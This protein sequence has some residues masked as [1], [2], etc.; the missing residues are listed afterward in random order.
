[1]KEN[2]ET[3]KVRKS[4]AKATDMRCRARGSHE[5]A[6]ALVEFVLSSGGKTDMTAEQLAKEMGWERRLGL[7][8]ITDMPRF[9]RARNHI[10]DGKASDGKQCTG[11]SIHY[12]TSARENV[13]M[14]VDPEGD[15]G[16]RK[17]V[18]ARE[19]AGDVQ[20]QVAFRTVNGRRIA[21]AHSMADMCLHFDPSDV[22]G[23][24]LMTTYA[25]ELKRF[26]APTDVTIAEI[27]VWL[28]SVT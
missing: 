6:L 26:G 27:N 4:Y 13:W 5:D 28:Q 10:R 22:E 3:R 19:I 2:R 1:M 17:E 23:Y 20:Q 8:R 21:T 11:Y 7:A 24:Q 16:H 18:A 9:Q 14:L 15:L 12:R 25:M